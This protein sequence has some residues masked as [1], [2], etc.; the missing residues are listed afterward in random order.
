VASDPATNNSSG[1]DRR[2]E[3]AKARR[4]S[5]RAFDP[6]SPAMPAGASL[7][8]FARMRSSARRLWTGCNQDG[9][10]LA[11]R[12]APC[13][14]GRPMGSDQRI[15]WSGREGHVE[16]TAA[17]NRLFAEAIL[18]RERAG[19]PDCCAAFLC[20]SQPSWLPLYAFFLLELDVPEGCCRRGLLEHRGGGPVDR[21]RL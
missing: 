10:D 7:P 11:D 13:I 17:D 19:F 14:A 21:H 16:G 5:S 3:A 4:S 12:W 9:S 6:H 2:I 18:C 15:F 20:S 8:R 1:C